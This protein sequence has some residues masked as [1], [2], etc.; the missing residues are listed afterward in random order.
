MANRI[1]TTGLLF[2]FF[3]SILSFSTQSFGS[4]PGQGTLTIIESGSASGSDCPLEHTSVKAEISGFV[5]R[6]SVTQIF[7][8]PGK[9]KI[10]AVY[11]FPLSSDGAVDNMTMRVGERV[12]RGEIKRREEARRVYEEAKR[13]GNMA[14][15]LDQERPNIFTQSV[16]NILPGEKM[17]IS[18]EYSEILTYEDGAFKFVFPMV[19]GP[20]FIPGSPTGHQGTGWAPDT[21]QVP[22]ASAITPP[23][24]PK[25][26][27]AGHDIDLQVS[28]DAGVPIGAV[29]SKLHDI[30]VIRNGPNRARVQ[31]RNKKEIPNKDFI[32]TYQVAG[33]EIRSGVL[34]HRSGKNG[35]ATVIVIPPKKVTPDRISPKEMI[36]VIDCSGSQRRKPLEKAKE[37]MRYIIDNMNP[38]DTFNIIDFNS[39]AR[40]LFAEARKNS[41]ENRAKA[42]SYLNS[43]EAQGGTWMG[44]AV[45]KVCNS[46]APSNRLRIVT[47]MTDGYVG[48]D[49]EIISLVKQLRGKSRWF[50]FGTG[51]S[52]N[53]F[54]LDQMARV[55]GGEPEYILLN[56]PGEEI[57][58]KF[59]SRIATPVLTDITLRYEGMTLE[60]VYPEAVADL[61]AQKPMIFK[62]RYSDPGKGTVTVKGFAGGKPYTQVLNVD[63]PEKETRNASLPSLWARSKVDDLMDRDWM[64]VQRGTPDQGIKD[65][66]VKTALEYRLMTQFTSFVAVEEAIV[67]VGGEP[68]RVVVPV[69]MPDGV[70]REGVFGEQH[71]QLPQS[72]RPGRPIPA[73][74][75]LSFARRAGEP[76]QSVLAKAENEVKKADEPKRKI[77]ALSDA[78]GERDKSNDNR[79]SKLSSELQEL[80]RTLKEKGRKGLDEQ[81]KIKVVKGS[82][83]VLVWLS[84]QSDAAVKLLEEA[85]LKISF[86]S[87]GKTLIGTIDVEKLEDL[88]K[89][90]EVRFVEQPTTAS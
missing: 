70:S 75:A 18:I 78:A 8:N 89:V 19:V 81:S 46:P 49:F 52:V 21:T 32:M 68:T 87:G 16:A 3:I 17:E 44:P 1:R 53:R 23:V 64:G 25:G 5:A 57:A 31:L 66:I 82:V 58:K 41:A 61:W 27:R 37:T 72:T 45:E 12:I 35:Y 88:L 59:Y 55:G 50:P 51:H 48:N 4:V 40:A 33:D 24:T 42:I 84:D 34:T 2:L 14:S 36:F 43:L 30:E 26:T 47:F 38:D 56:S 20:R 29:E 71:N 67:T 15:L 10:E 74:G 73:E 22:D 65:E 54:L 60:E 77:G 9:D 7:R 76:L 6:V 86:R 90:P 69:E 11:T 83:T 63:L 85:G 28:M 39:G 80:I 62:A 79:E 13:R